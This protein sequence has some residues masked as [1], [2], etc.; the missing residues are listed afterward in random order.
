MHHFETAI[1]VLGG[2]LVVGALLSSIAKRS[3]LSLTALFVL[4]GFVLG[5][6]GLEVLHFEARSGFVEE[7]ATSRSW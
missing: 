4:A 1:A 2:L 6:G 5:D 7:L 3:F